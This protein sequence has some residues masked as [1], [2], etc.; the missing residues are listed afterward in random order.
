M[1]DDAIMGVASPDGNRI[2]FF[3]GGNGFEP[4]ELWFAD[5]DG[6]DLQQVLV[7][8]AKHNFVSQVAWSPHGN[9]IAYIRMERPGPGAV[10]D[11]DHGR[12]DTRHQDAEGSGRLADALCWGPD[13]RLFYGYQP[14]NKGERFSS[15][16]YELS[17]NEETGAAEGPERNSPM[18]PA[19]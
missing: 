7:P 1:I 6:S 4:R 2:A 12:E 16:V 17:V 5:N 18:A 15:V 8:G 14:E 3:R 11:R 13:G 10:G 19:S 9:R